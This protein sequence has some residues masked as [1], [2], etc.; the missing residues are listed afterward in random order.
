MNAQNLTRQTVIPE[1]L[2]EIPEF[3]PVYE[4]H[5]VDYDEVIPHVLMGDFVRFLFDAY[6]KSQTDHAN[7]QHWQHLINRIL[8]LMERAIG[9]SDEYVENLISA[10]FVEN[11]SPS[12]EQDK[13]IYEALKAQLGPGLRRALEFHDPT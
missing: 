13:E 11:L 3:I 12:E 8:G 9:S 2:A 4:E 1:L 6:R 7:S 5:M 10:S